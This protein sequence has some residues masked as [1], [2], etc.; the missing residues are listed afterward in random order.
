MVAKDI[1]NNALTSI[2]NAERV[3]KSECIINET[4]KL[5]IEILK[6]FQRHGYIGEFEVIES[7]YAKPAIVKLTHK[8][9]NCQVIKPRFYV[10]KKEILEKEIQY[11]PARD[12]G[13][14][15]L[16]TSKG[17]LTH[18]EAKEKGVGGALLCY[19]Y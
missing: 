18:K 5:V 4:S 14:L 12:V 15:I 19:V 6:I 17:I 10:T 9:N 11:L 16:T 8:I 1:L 7:I 13:L 3:G 2:R